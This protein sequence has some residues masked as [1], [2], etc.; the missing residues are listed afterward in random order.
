MSYLFSLK[1][2]IALVASPLILGAISACSFKASMTAG[3]SKTADNETAPE[4]ASSEDSSGDNS[5]KEDAAKPQ[6]TASEAKAKPAKAKVTIK[7]SQI[8]LG[9]PAQ[10]DRETATLSSAGNEILV[11]LVRY[12]E[13]NARMTQLRIEGH[14]HNQ[15]PETDS[16]ALSGQRAAALKAWLIQQGV[17]AERIL[18]VGFGLSQ[19]LESNAN[20]E[21]Q[22]KNE[23]TVFHIA[24]VDGKPY[25]GA[26]PLAGGTEF[27]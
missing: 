1:T 5:A 22:A 12:L 23:R 10:F 6:D 2:R 15:R 13:Q 7:G 25:L 19:P 27:P 8:V 24:T 4:N 18:A 21:G 3:G 9:G 11:E 26:D 17:A 16:L 20:A 14:T